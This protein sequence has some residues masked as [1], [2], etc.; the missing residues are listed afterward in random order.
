MLFTTIIMQVISFCNWYY[1]KK[2]MKKLIIVILIFCISVSYSQIDFV[3]PHSAENNIF[4]SEIILSNDTTHDVKFYHL[5]LEIG[6]D[7][8]YIKGNVEYMLISKKDSLNS[9]LLDLDE[10]FTVDS[11][12]FPAISFSENRITLKLDRDYSKGEKVSFKIYYQ[13]VPKLQGA[14]KGLVYK[15]HDNDQPVIVSLSTPYLAH[16]W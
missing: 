8:K 1:T 7:N 14:Y 4:N 16:K 2:I 6:I 12:S 11:I 15:T 3:N 13:G 5:D 10:V 9:I